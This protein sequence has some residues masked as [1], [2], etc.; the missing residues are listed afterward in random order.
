MSRTP[1]QREADEIDIALA[2]L[3]GRME[4]HCTFDGPGF[5]DWNEARHLLA[6]ARNHVRRRMSAKDRAATPY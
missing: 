5:A 4:R 2:R 3:L 1:E 6:C